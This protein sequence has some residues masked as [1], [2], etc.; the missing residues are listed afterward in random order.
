[1]TVF[2]LPGHGKSSDALDPERSYNLTAYA[3]VASKVLR[4]LK[5]TSVIVFG[6]SLGGHVGHELVAL[7]AGIK[8]IDIK[9]LMVTGAP[10]SSGITQLLESFN[11]DP[12][13]NIAVNEVLTDEEVDMIILYGCGAEKTPMLEEMVRRADG[14]ARK[15]MTEG[16]KEWR[17]VD[18]RKVVA[19]MTVPL[20]VVHG[21]ADPFIKLDI[22]DGLKYGN[23][24]GG[25]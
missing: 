15:F 17:G 13:N 14:R 25:G 5:V 9:G 4:Q 11:V 12:E 23:L 3:E 6:A 24:W 22:V 1:V 20:A 8:E 16:M 7:V 18:Q 19:E 21:A 2:D 10:P